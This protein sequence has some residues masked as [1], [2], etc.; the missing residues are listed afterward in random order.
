MVLVLL[1]VTSLSEGK[2]LPADARSKHPSPVA[3]CSLDPESQSE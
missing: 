1:L 2:H 3:A